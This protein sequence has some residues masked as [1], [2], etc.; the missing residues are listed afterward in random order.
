V[1]GAALLLPA[2]LV[3]GACSLAGDIT[4]PPALATAQAQGI[5]LPPTPAP[6]T[7][8][9]QAPDLAAGALIYADKCAPCHGE[10]GDG[11]GPQ[12]SALPN[13]P[14][15]LREADVA[16]RALPEEWFAI[17]TEGRIESFMPGFTSLDDQQRWDVVGYALGLGLPSNEV[18]LGSD[19]FQDNCAGCH[20]AQGPDFA[21]AEYLAGRSLL[22]IYGAITEGVGE[23]M[24]GYAENL[25]DEQRW[26]LAAYIRSLALAAAP[27]AATS[28]PLPQSTSTGGALAPT[29]PEGDL[30]A[31]PTESATT[32]AEPVA[33]AARITGRVIQGTA[34]ERPP[35]DLEVTLHGFDGDQESLTQ[36][37][38]LAG[39][40]FAF[41][42]IEPALGRVYVVTA[43]YQEVLYASEIGELRDTPELELPLTVFESTAA[44]EAVEISRLHLL[45]DFPAEGVVQ[46]VELW[47]LSNLGDRTVYGGETGVLEVALPE[48]ASG[49]SLDGG[50]IG[51]RFELTPDGFRDRQELVPGENTGEL[52]F[53][54][55][56]PYD[57]SLE[58]VRQPAYPVA[59]T[60]AM[61]SGDGP[62]VVGEQFTDMGLRQVSGASLHSYERGPAEA[63]DAIRLT[64]QGRPSFGGGA[65]SDLQPIAIGAA[66]LV[67]ALVGAG[68]IWFRPKRERDEARETVGAFDAVDDEDKVL[69]A[70]ASL[71]N[72]FAAGKIEAATYQT[73]RA[74]LVRSLQT[75][76]GS[77]AQAAERD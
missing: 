67:L 72:D 76:K 74:D 70:I 27:E 68:L 50:T 65:P 28:A 18:E 77:R 14:A 38:R 46:V 54:Y 56:L 1:K 19:L 44:T 15:A 11:Q 62:R 8:P 43:D 75:A 36:T 64:L 4:P 69:W 42:G 59:A 30:T 45:F 63:G 32:T 49:L 21:S 29:L 55:N 35:A 60:V 22:A 39:G 5:G 23:A 31:A 71:D 57:G 58:L 61:I 41:E 25:S 9:R 34:G 37:Q 53:S 26:A 7:V 52:V 73:R 48:G 17:V 20:A 12:A 24:P 66:A 33:A 16:Q 51:D 10:T 40:A 2:A 6:L 47:L 3:L 13:P